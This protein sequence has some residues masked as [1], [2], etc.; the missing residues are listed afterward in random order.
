MMSCSIAD[1]ARLGAVL[2]LIEAGKPTEF[3]TA[4]TA[5]KLP[6]LRPGEAGEGE[7]FFG[8]E[9][10]Y[11]AAFAV[12]PSR[13]LAIVVESNAGDS[14]DLC[15]AAIHG[16]RE[17]VAPESPGEPA[18]RGRYG[19]VIRAEGDDSW[20]VAEVLADSPAFAAG[21]KPGDRIMAIHGQPLAEIDP[22]GRMALLKQSPVK[23]KIDRNGESIEIEMRLP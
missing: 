5:A 3:L 16:V 17:A 12:W 11:T 18:Q 22:D 4:A 6:E 9:G 20:I 23:L 21:L 8:G 13:G 1:F 10:H 2:A 7:I 19:F 15:E 14:D